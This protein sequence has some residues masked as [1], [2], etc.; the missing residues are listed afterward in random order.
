MECFHTNRHATLSTTQPWWTLMPRYSNATPTS[1]HT[2][3]CTVG[4][5][6]AWG[7][8]HDAVNSLLES[9]PN[10]R[11]QRS[12]H[13]TWQ[14]VRATFSLLDLIVQRAA[15]LAAFIIYFVEQRKTHGHCCRVVSEV[16]PVDNQ[17]PGL[18]VV[19]T[20][21]DLDFPVLIIGKAFSFLVPPL[22]RKV[23]LG[24]H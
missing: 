2:L 13:L 23:F 9:A 4:S 17:W 24:L 8:D 16:T 10:F 22:R 3:S 20:I 15:S 21:P 14:P 18:R 1:R 12:A 5:F 7:G 19:G 6:L 11:L